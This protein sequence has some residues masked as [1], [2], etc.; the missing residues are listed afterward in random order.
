MATT[1]AASPEP[2]RY[3]HFTQGTIPAWSVLALALC[4]TVLAWYVTDA[5]TRS[6]ERQRFKAEINA[7]RLDL[8][9]R[10]HAYEQVLRGG[11]SVFHS[12]PTV[13]R[14]SWRSYIE[15]LQIAEN[16]PGIQGIGFSQLIRPADR[17]SHVLAVRAEGL[18]EYRIWPEGER[19]IYTS[20]VYLEPPDWRNQRALGFDMFQEPVRRAAMERA[21]DTGLA[22]LSGRVT[23][24]QET[25]QAI[26]PGFLMYLPVYET[27]SPA[28]EAQRRLQLVGYVYSPFRMR[29]FM[30]GLLGGRDR[31]VAMQVFDGPEPTEEALL[32]EG[33]AW[34]ARYAAEAP[35]I[36]TVRVALGGRTWTLEFA[37]LPSMGADRSEPQLVAAGGLVTSFLLWVITLV[38]AS[39]RAQVTAANQQLRLDIARREQIEAQLRDTESS[40]RYL[41]EKNPN[42]MW[43]FDRETLEILE[44]NDAAVKH[45]GYPR[46]E[47]RRMRITELRPAEEVPR[48]EEFLRRRGTGLSASGEW[49]HLTKDGRRIDVEIS[50]YTLEFQHR[51]ATLVVARDITDSKRAE[52]RLLEGQKMEAVGQLTGGL[53]HD[54]NNILTVVLG[55]AEMLEIALADD[56]RLRPLAEMITQSAQRG[57]ELTHRLLAFA[58]QQPLNPE[59]VDVN[60]L[61][62]GLQDLLRRTLGEHVEIR[63][64]CGRG[65]WKAMV[66][67]GQLESA[68]LN[69]AINARDA[70]P[71][72]G[73]LVIETRN[74]VLDEHY[75]AQHANVQAGEYVLLAVSDSGGG[76]APDD[77][78]RVL[79]PFYT[80]KEKGK[81]TGL[82][83]AMVY[84]FAK[85]SNGHLK[86]YSELGAGTTVNLYLPRAVGDDEPTSR[87]PRTSVTQG[88]TETVLLVEDDALVRS[89]AETQLAAL[90][91]QV[92]SAGD[93][94]E[95]LEII[96][97]QQDIDLLF[98]DVIMP[99]GLNGRELAEAARAIRP[100]L[101]VLF[102]SGYTE[103]AIV[104][105]G[106][107]D[108]GVTLLGKPYRRSELAAKVREALADERPGDNRR[109]V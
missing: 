54:F 32:Y 104:H 72:G 66:D 41:F 17:R 57:A 30:R 50:G 56:G 67:A 98:T 18:P 1:L 39:H 100:E 19:D 23:L 106:R 68:L 28:D 11:V 38:L 29:D 34:D 107:L 42:P 24:V 16:Y 63:L 94:P 40:F 92:V 43:V 78:E 45:Y 25:D 97:K 3:G 21:R 48:L 64:E 105:H 10:L 13:T 95:A 31:R 65:M 44:V 77:L 51:P 6:E 12:W 2:R 88:G 83:L 46:E 9:E 4:G 14:A 101:K 80:T 85:Q 7:V 55:N 93:G 49:Q 69:L 103:N 47:F 82:G 22:S 60:S 73:K 52:A 62:R 5:A 96:R 102:T 15:N 61:V 8:E 53:A 91:Y 36:E 87:Q 108:P 81:G 90:G 89:Y 35:F 70:M 71:Q 86:L 37:A 27:P 59:I 58:R 74:V 26:Q 75:A 79:E 76:I 84:G 20:V 33:R 109:D 99:G